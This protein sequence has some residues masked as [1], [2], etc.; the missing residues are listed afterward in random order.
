MKKIIIIHCFLVL[1]TA[2]LMSQNS[3]GVSEIDKFHTTWR[4]SFIHPTI[5]QN[6]TPASS[7]DRFGFLMGLDFQVPILDKMIHDH[8]GL[9]LE[10]GL[11]S[12]VSMDGD[13]EGGLASLRVPLLVK[14]HVFKKG[15]YGVNFHLGP[16]L[17]YCIMELED[18]SP[19]VN[20][21]VMNF[22]VGIGFNIGSTLIDFRYEW[23]LK[24]YLKSTDRKLRRLYFGISF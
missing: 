7:T 15:N 19:G 5:Y 2:S 4:I 14:Y 22:M 16:A 13:V 6:G 23:G 18:P 12:S 21:V 11:H 17:E 3:G 10:I 8:D 24:S 1:F 9:G 20:T